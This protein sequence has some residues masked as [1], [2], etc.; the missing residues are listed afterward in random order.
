MLNQGQ[1]TMIWF[2]ESEPKVF[3]ELTD[4]DCIS[5]FEKSPI[6]KLVYEIAD[7]SEVSARG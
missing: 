6:P 4:A 1:V 5:T 3:V 7:L 2:Q